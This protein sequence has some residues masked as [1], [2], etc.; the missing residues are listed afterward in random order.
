MLDFER[1]LLNFSFEEIFLRR[2]N[3][4]SFAGEQTN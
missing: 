1:K 3:E 4:M 2:H